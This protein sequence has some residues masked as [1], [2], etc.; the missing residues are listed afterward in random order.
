M[1]PST[2]GLGRHDLAAEDFGPALRIVQDIAD[3]RGEL[4]AHN[5]LG[6]VH[7]MLGRQEEAIG[8]CRREY[9]VW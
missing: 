6:Q 4:T 1:A 2:A 8:R 9:D 5:G 3:R 7:R